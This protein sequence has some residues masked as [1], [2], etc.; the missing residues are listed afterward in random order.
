[1]LKM[2]HLFVLLCLISLLPV[3]AKGDG[4]VEKDLA[5][6][7]MTEE[8]PAAGKRVRQV[9][10]EYKG[11]Q[12]YHALYLPVDWKPGGKYPVIVEYTG[13]EFPPGKGSGEVKDANLGYGM[14][15]G[16]GFIWVSMPYVEKGRKKNAVTW[17]G[18]KQAT[19]DY[20]KVNLPRICQQFGGDP[21]NVFICG[22]S[23]GAIGASYIGLADDEIAA[24]W[25][26]MFTHD[27]FD[28][29]KQ[30]GYPESDRKSA[31]VRLRRLKGRPVLICGMRA[32]TIRD[33][34]LKD[35]IDL[36]RFTFLDV[37]TWQIFE[38]PEGKV[39]NTHTDLWMHRESKYRQRA[40]AWLQEVLFSAPTLQAQQVKLGEL[41]LI[42]TEDEIPIRYDGSLSTLRKDG[43]MH[44]FHSFG[45]RLKPGQTRRS[46]HSWHKGPPDDPL[47]CHVGSKT[48]EALWDYNGY[49]QDLAEQGLWILGMYECPNGDMLAITH[50]ELNK[51]H[52]GM[53]N[54]AD[55][56]FA[57]GL[58]YSTDR[59]LSW[60]Y[61]GEI[62]RPA[63]D[64]HNVGGGAY[65]IR[66]DYLYVYFNDIIPG[67]AATRPNRIQSV[68]RA[69]LDAVIKAAAQHQ[70]IPWHK[71]RDGKWDIPGLSGKPGEDLIP[72]I[73]GGE[74]LH[75]DAAYCT[76]L[77]KY[78]LTVQTHAAG[79]LL[80]FS[81]PDGLDWSLETTV[82]QASNGVIQP[83]STFVD[84]DGPSAD[85]HTVDNDFYLYFP[86]KGPDSNTDH[87]YRRRITIEGANP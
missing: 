72:H 9:A 38:I 57:L 20:C 17:W 13:N 82:D 8:A 58:G 83:Y 62:V 30:W 76:A 3:S 27:H 26:G 67:E 69:R 25:K 84:F 70:V 51:A 35:H 55:Q 80:L 24:L 37:P 32:S 29:Q 60:T 47:K 33:Q 52:E 21:D 28:G 71:Y 39:V 18:D 23:R 6:P 5:T 87:M 45:C 1:M 44:F 7:V 53:I 65:I 61:C 34:Y 49:Y 14:S 54:R 73:T 85:C 4:E 2:Q 31:L 10:P 66:G 68:A 42:Y 78:L 74:D 64:R 56:R 40:R 12:V 43:E 22:F 36:A 46:R 63:D 15:G 16:R 86:R 77:G 19:V 50:A 75:A 41:K 48:D 59:G 81:S 79:R 11:T